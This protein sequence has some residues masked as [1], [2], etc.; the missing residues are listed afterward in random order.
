MQT[1]IKQTYT[2]RHTYRKTDRKIDKQTEG[3]TYIYTQINADGSIPINV[4]YLLLLYD[5]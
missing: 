4:T 3:Q 2:D 5:K 1:D